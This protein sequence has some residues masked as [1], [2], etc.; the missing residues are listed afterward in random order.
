MRARQGKAAGDGGEKRLKSLRT[1]GR[2]E[3]TGRSGQGEGGDP[4]QQQGAVRAG[5]WHHKGLDVGPGVGL[6]PLLLLQGGEA[7]VQT[8]WDWAPVSRAG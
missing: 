1:Q 3:E 7:V 8:L 2:K 6:S 4:R 5:E